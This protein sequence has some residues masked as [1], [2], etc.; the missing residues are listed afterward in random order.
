MFWVEEDKIYTLVIEI[1]IQVRVLT[2]F[3]CFSDGYFAVSIV[4]ACMGMYNVNEKVKYYTR[5]FCIIVWGDTYVDV[6]RQMEGNG[7][8]KHI[9]HDQG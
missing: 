3:L 8:S 1:I 6:R 7:M 4:L 5:V 2:S 9:I